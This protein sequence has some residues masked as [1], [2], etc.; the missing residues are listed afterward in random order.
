MMIFI[1][2][3]KVFQYQFLDSVQVRLLFHCSL[4]HKQNDRSSLGITPRILVTH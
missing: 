4:S 3:R 1:H 2:L